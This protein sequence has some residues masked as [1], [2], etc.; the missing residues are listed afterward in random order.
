VTGDRR[1][2]GGGA[3]PV[4]AVPE[5][6]ADRKAPHAPSKV[7]DASADKRAATGGKIGLYL[8]IGF[9]VDLGYAIAASP[10]RTYT[11]VLRSEHPGGRAFQDG[12]GHSDTEIAGDLVFL[13]GMTVGLRPGVIEPGPAYERAYR[14]IGATLARAGSS[15]EDVIGMTSYG[16]GVAAP[17]EPMSMVHKSFVC[18]PY[19]AWT[20]IDVNRLLPE[21]DIAESKVI[22]RHSAARPAD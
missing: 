5:E 17:I 12:Y 15:C 2:F 11:T 19:P 1:H 18:A 22:A 21:G 16:T 13:S 4:V 7:A 14:Q 20:A 6:P 8:L 10:E 9:V 3:E